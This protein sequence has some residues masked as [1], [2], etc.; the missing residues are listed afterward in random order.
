MKE[1]LK[2][3]IFICI[4]NLLFIY[5]VINPPINENAK[6][7]IRMQVLVVRLVFL[8]GILMILYGFS[9]FFIDAFNY[10]KYGESYLK[11]EICTV[12]RTFHLPIFFFAKKKVACK[13]GQYFKKFITFDDYFHN[14]KFIFYYLPKSK[15]IV[16]QELIYSPNEKNEKGGFR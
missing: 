13:N 15:I 16:K 8:S 5:L 2:I 10:F 4:A 3:L 6:L 14:E 11:K 9:P 1:I 12:E 7:S